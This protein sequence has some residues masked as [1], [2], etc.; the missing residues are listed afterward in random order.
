MGFENNLFLHDGVPADS[1][2]ELVG[3]VWHALSTV[4]L[5]TQFADGLREEI[6]A[7]MALMNAP[8]WRRAAKLA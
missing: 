6:A 3:T 7:T 5:G 2:A 8:H 1:N 4:G